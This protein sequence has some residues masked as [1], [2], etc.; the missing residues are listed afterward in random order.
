MD[1]ILILEITDRRGNAIMLSLM[2]FYMQK[3]VPRVGW[4]RR[5]NKS[6]ANADGV[7]LGYH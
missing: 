1:G 3:V 6:T 2:R 5:R 7:L 4:L